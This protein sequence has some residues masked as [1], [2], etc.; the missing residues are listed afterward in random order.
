MANA[1]FLSGSTSSNPFAAV[2]NPPTV[3]YGTNS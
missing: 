1:N 2:T 3:V